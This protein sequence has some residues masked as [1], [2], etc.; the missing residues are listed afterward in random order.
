MNDNNDN[1]LLITNLLLPDNADYFSLYLINWHKHED[2]LFPSLPT[3]NVS[4]HLER[5]FIILSLSTCNFNVALRPKVLTQT[6]G[7]SHPGV[8]KL[9]L[10][11]P[12]L[13]PLLQGLV[14]AEKPLSFP[15]P[16]L[17]N[18]AAQQAE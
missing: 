13:H 17:L 2:P 11:T 4:R 3:F 15:E 16:E 18:P 10:P 14:P 5:N 1:N 12:V 6:Q 7:F 9:L 8:L